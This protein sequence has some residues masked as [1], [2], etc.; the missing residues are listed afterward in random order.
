MSSTD[1][2]IPGIG[3]GIDWTAFINKVVTVETQ[4]VQRTLYR[5]QVVASAAKTTYAG[6]QGML[7]ALRTTASGFTYAKDFKTKS[8]TSSDSSVLTG[9]ATVTAINQSATVRVEQLA[10]NEKWIASFTGVSDSVTATDGQLVINVR[11]AAKTVDVAAGRTLT[12]LAD[13]INAAHIG[14]TAT[15][16]SVSDGSSNQARLVLTDDSTG[17]ADADNTTWHQNI[18]FTSSTLTGLATGAFTNQVQG[19]D[20]KAIING[21][22]VYRDANEVADVLPGLTLTLLKADPGVDKAITVTES[23]ADAASKIGDFV[24]R[25]NSL[26]DALKKAVAFDSSGASA[27]NPTA[28]DYTLRGVLSQLTGSV[29]GS[30][31]TLPG[32]ATITSLADIGISTKFQAANGAENGHLMFDPAKFS[33]ALA[34]NFDGV[35]EFFEGKTV[36]AA[37]TEIKYQGFGEYFYKVANSFLEAGTGSIS[38]RIANLDEEYSRLDKEITVKMDR[39]KHKQE[40]LKSKFA[41]LES[42]LS[43]LA[44][45]QN[46]M[47]SLLGSIALNNQAIAGR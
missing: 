41:H 43:K 31:R 17:Q 47:S 3:S 39:I 12:E 32:D 24:A 34:S 37:E 30:V 36:G 18:S 16:F 40:F 46:S 6:I 20:A 35:V 28:G 27:S 4:A 10:T 25:Y 21:T 23:T 13:D 45:R 2:S 15:V 5:K 44:A 29:T 1:F 14:V 7:D 42:V 33:A 8:V 19:A 26:I 11:G 9:I 22:T 38:T